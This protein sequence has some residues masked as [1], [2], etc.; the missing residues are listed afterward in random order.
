MRKGNSMKNVFLIL[1]FALLVGCVKDKDRK[2]PEPDE[3]NVTEETVPEAE[4]TIAEIAEA[5]AEETGSLEVETDTETTLVT[6]DST[7]TSDEELVEEVLDE[8]I[9]GTPETETTEAVTEETGTPETE[10]TETVTEETG[11]LETET[12]DAET[13]EAT[14]T[15]EEIAEETGFYLASD[16]IECNIVD[17]AFITNLEN[18]DNKRLLDTL[19]Y[20][21]WLYPSS[22]AD[23]GVTG[24]RAPELEEWMAGYSGKTCIW[25]E[26]GIQGFFGVRNYDFLC[27]VPNE[28]GFSSTEPIALESENS[29]IEEEVIVEAEPTEATSGTEEASE[30]ESENV[31][32]TFEGNIFYTN[33]NECSRELKTGALDGSFWNFKDYGLSEDYCIYAKDSEFR[34]VPRWNNANLEEFVQGFNE[35]GFQNFCKWTDQRNYDWLCVDLNET[36]Y[37]FPELTEL[38]SDNFIV[39]EEKEVTEETIE[40]PVVVYGSEFG[41]DDKMETVIL[42][43]FDQKECSEELKAGVLRGS[44]WKADSGVNSELCHIMGESRGALD[45]S[46][47]LEHY[48][49]LDEYVKTVTSEGGS[50]C[51]WSSKNSKEFLCEMPLG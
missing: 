22:R 2:Q 35:Q 6:V 49:L 43:Y 46:Y 9:L 25:E 10:T 19:D 42:F 33:L 12:T 37:L 39:E 29:T 3:P 40:E 23:E 4:G 30:T 20:C 51:K 34:G 47:P 13:T 16:V 7:D 50:F 28:Q 18:L 15:T 8:L 32:S 36:A 48:L 41:D 5:D 31:E 27:F 45:A 38:E 24:R 17:K 14:E 1:S 21:E 11:S 44:F 26:G